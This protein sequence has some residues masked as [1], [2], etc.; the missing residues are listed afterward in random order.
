MKKIL[1]IS[2]LIASLA[3]AQVNVQKTSGTNV[4]SNGPIVVGNGNSITA[5]GNGTIVATSAGNATTVPW[6]GVTGTPTT[7][8]GYGITNT[9][10]TTAPLTGGGTIASGLTL[11]IPAATG[12]VSGYLTSADWTTFNSKQPAGSY[13]TLTGNN[14]FTG[15]NSFTSSTNLGNVS[16]GGQGTLTIAGNA[17]VPSGTLSLAYVPSGE[18]LTRPYEQLVG[19]Y[20]ATPSA[21]FVARAALAN[22]SVGSSLAK[23]AFIGDSTTEGVPLVSNRELKSWPAKFTRTLNALGCNLDGFGGL[24]GCYTNNAG[25]WPQW[26]WSSSDWF[27]I[28]VNPAIQSNGSSKVATFT[29]TNTG[30]ITELYYLNSGASFTYTIDG[31]APRTVITTGAQSMGVATVS[32]LANTPHTLVV[33]SGSNSI[34]VGAEVHSSTT[35]L[36][37]WN[38][39]L[40]G[41]T[42]SDW[43]FSAN[44][45]SASNLVRLWAPQLTCIMLGINDAGSSVPVA[46]YKANMQGIITQALTTGSVLLITPTPGLG[47]NDS[48][49]VTALYQLAETNNV[50][51][52]DL[53]DRFGSYAVANAAGLYGDGLHLSEAGNQALATT[54]AGVIS[55]AANP[56]IIT[57]VSLSG[58]ANT[59]TALPNSALTN[60]A[61]TIGSTS[62]ALGASAASLTGLGDVSSSTGNFSSRVNITGGDST[63]ALFVRDVGST[64]VGGAFTLGKAD[65]AQRWRFGLRTDGGTLTDDFYFIGFTGSAFTKT[66]RLINATGNIEALSTADASSSDAALISDGGLLVKKSIYATTYIEGVE[67]ASS[68]TAPST[69]GFRIYAKDNGA[70]KTVVYIRF[71]TGAE[72]QIAIEP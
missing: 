29:S 32:G 12:S 6:S 8:T 63:G 69:N 60:S 57:G 3:T 9:L 37:F 49:Y 4:L 27:P 71:A 16:F 42:S 59:V 43:Y 21:L 46:T 13:P 31:G 58:A 36:R 2:A 10:A 39:G 55:V 34:L 40:G 20:N 66:L 67:Q 24:L 65:G 56:S 52:I 68:P 23:I 48:D 64:A 62:V 25:Y 26:V 47:I 51:L 72:Q 17:S 18:T 50:P 45:F 28:S 5:T 35:G 54:V 22:A 30:T 53:N 33:T 7:M 1:L 38:A 41:S 19:V 15:S 14:T 61:V 44:W 70:G 11:A